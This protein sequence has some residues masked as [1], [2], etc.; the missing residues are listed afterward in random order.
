MN[1]IPRMFEKSLYDLIRGLRNHKGNEREYIQNS[2]R[3]CRAEIKGA[4]MDLKATAL[5][6]LVYMEMFGYD[7][8]W[9]S[10]HVLEVMSSQR[11]PQKRVGYLAAVQSFRPDTEVLMLATNL[12]KKDV[13]SAQVP[14]ISLP[15]ISLPHVNT[16]S[17]ALSLSSD[18]LTR[19][20][21]SNPLV[22]KKTVVTLYRL[23]LVHPE[24]LK[25]AWPKIKDILMNE[26]ED[27]SVTA[28]VV[29][30]VC[31]LGW[32][33]PQDFLPL[34]PR[35]FE[36]L[37]D[38][39]NNWMAIKII[40][41]FA[42]LTPLEPRLVKKLLP[43]LTNLIRTTPAMSLLYECING[44]IQ[45]GIFKSG[46]SGEE[47]DE[48]ARLCAGKLRDMILVEDDPNCMYPTRKEVDV[49]TRSNPYVV[50]YVALLAFNHIILTHPILVS[51]HQDAILGCIDDLD[52]SIRL[53][54]LDLGS[55]MVNAENLMLI[56]ARLIK[57][58]KKAPLASIPEDGQDNRRQLIEPGAVSDS[59]DP[60]ESFQLAPEKNEDRMALPT[61]YRISIIR[62]ILDMCSKDTYSDITDFEWYI[63]TLSQLAKLVPLSDGPDL[64]N[65]PA[66]CGVAQDSIAAAIGLEFQNIAVR[67]N[68]VRAEVVAACTRIISTFGSDSGF[69]NI[70]LGGKSILQYAAWVVG[71][72]ASYIATP[73]TTMTDL[74]HTKVRTL[75]TQCICSYL[76]AIPK[77]LIA[78]TS[79]DSLSWTVERKSMV[80][81]LLVR[82]IHFLEPLASHSDLEVQNR[83]VELL[84]LLRL[85]A[86]AVSEHANDELKGPLLLTTVLPSLYTGEELKPVAAEAQSKIP[87]PE[88]LDLDT[89]INPNLATILQNAGED[90]RSSTNNDD[91][92]EFD[93][94]YNEIPTK[95]AI[96]GSSIAGPAINLLRPS[97][98]PSPVVSYQ[99]PDDSTLDP[100]TAA[101]KRTERRAKNKDDPFYIG[102]SEADA[103]DSGTSTPFH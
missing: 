88:D 15:L 6:K 61:D 98:A 32:R 40:K 35:L 76:L 72:Y 101:L 75:P 22:R 102:G 56:V 18:I 78:M 54:A 20:T 52:I 81:L 70:S 85:T 43:P 71:E 4:D 13:T 50:R 84:E 55:R 14:T 12:L 79:Y 7:M 51:T 25:V 65:D 53:Q 11:Y 46:D 57:Q 91:F 34:A 58:L 41:L 44:I 73:S 5:L 48:I 77:V 100:E 2:L 92:A 60:E 66:N 27:P 29:N 36:L 17:L 31:E 26:E 83:A 103:R 33:R 8:S 42:T 30:V 49:Q 97:E 28:A 45:G 10:F 96:Q 74:I 47:G 69:P 63:E 1:K 3:E 59:E 24:T 64:A 39:G 94:L 21:H 82:I 90:T 87:I 80:S 23:A 93:R 16:T 38:G 99:Q 95:K 62:R 9:A 86:Q 37:V 19:L 89:P 68:V 67:V